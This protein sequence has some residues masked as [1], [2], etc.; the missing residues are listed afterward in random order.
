MDWMTAL[1][2]WR[3]STTFYLANQQDQFSML[4]GETIA[5]LRDKVN[6][7]LEKFQ[8]SRVIEPMS[9]P[10]PWISSILAIPKEESE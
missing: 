9:I 2:H 5:T 10:T 4:P 6:Q 1:A 3:V 7:T 8:N